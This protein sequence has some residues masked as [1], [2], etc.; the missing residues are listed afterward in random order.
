MLMPG[1]S[2]TLAFRFHFSMIASYVPFSCSVS[3]ALRSDVGERRILR[4]HGALEEVLES[5][6]LALAGKLQRALGLL[7]EV[8][9]RRLGGEEGVGAVGLHREDRGR[10]VLVGLHVDR[11]LALVQHF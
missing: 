3:N 2:S 4:H 6:R 10:L 5:V 11:R 8:R 1:L 7:D 9:Q